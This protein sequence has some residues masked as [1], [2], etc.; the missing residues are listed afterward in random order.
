MSRGY[1]QRRGRENEC[2]AHRVCR[3]VCRV[4]FRVAGSSDVRMLWLLLPL[5]LASP[6]SSEQGWRQTEMSVYDSG[7]ASRKHS[8]TY[9]TRTIFGSPRQRLIGR[10]IE[11]QSLDGKEHLVGPVVGSMGRVRPSR[12]SRCRVRELDR[13]I[14]G[15]NRS[16]PSRHGGK[17]LQDVRYREITRAHALE[18][19]RVQKQKGKR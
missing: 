17:D 4:A 9:G 12:Y 10:W 5:L 14:P 15:C 6:L 8:R 18:L 2:V 7:V 13:W 3:G 19:I 11:V 1:C 16:L